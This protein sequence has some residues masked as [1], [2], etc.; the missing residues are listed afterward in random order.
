MRKLSWWIG[1]WMLALLPS[2]ALGQSWSPPQPLVRPAPSPLLD[3]P[4]QPSPSYWAAPPAAT[5]APAATAGA[6]A[7]GSGGGSSSS[8]ASGSS[9][10][11]GS[12]GDKLGMTAKWNDGLELQS[13]DKN[14]RVHVGG[15]YQMDAGWFAVDPNVQSHLLTAAAPNLASPMYADGVDFRRARFRVDGTLYKTIDW[16][17]EMDFVNSLRTAGLNP[18]PNLNRRL[19]QSTVALTDFWW[20][21][22][23]VPWF[24]TVR[25][26]QQKE[27]I[28]FEHLVSSR[29][30]PFMERSYNQDTFYGGT[31]NGFSPGI[32]AFRN[33]GEEDMG[34]LHLG[35]YKPLDNVFG[36]NSGNGDFALTGRVTRL[37][38]WED[39]GRQ[40][41]HLGLSGRQATAVRQNQSARSI[42]FRTRDAIRTGISQDWPVPA[43]IRLF[44]DDMQTVNAELAGVFGPWTL[45]AEYLVNSLQ[46]ARATAA[47]PLGVNAVYHGGYVQ[48]LYYLT[49]DHDHYNKATGVFERVRPSQN[50]AYGSAGKGSGAWQVGLRYN[51]LDLNDSG[52]NGGLL[53]NL[54]F[55]LNWFWNPN[56]KM[57][58]NY[59][60]TYRD[61]TGMTFTVPGDGNGWINGFGTR[62]AFDF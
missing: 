44:G 7:S 22:R 39:E 36:Y 26:G 48:L 62:L 21:F 9:S 38:W 3:A 47:G 29:F 31:F 56:M 2:W 15:R 52:L 33:W 34:V 61:T 20:Q 11:G 12:S 30:L 51:Y 53:H 59:I 55:G 28:G 42:D 13:A 43:G 32:A 23:E 58:F 5:D 8:G 50:F 4:P 24:G 57:Q 10:S 25:I 16:A 27:P 41:L 60:A 40:L 37:L 14:F 54:T 1:L 45:Q 17:A 49:G 18:D 35:L 19:D 46:N 6:A